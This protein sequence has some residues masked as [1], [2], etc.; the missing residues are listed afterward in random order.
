MELCAMVAAVATVL[1]EHIPRRDCCVMASGVLSDILNEGSY[2][3]RLLPVKVRALPDDG[4]PLMI[5]YGAEK[6]RNFWDG[7]LVAVVD[8]RYLVDVT[9]DQLSNSLAPVVTPIDVDALMSGADVTVKIPGYGAIVYTRHSSDGWKRL[10][11]ARPKNRRP[12]VE[13]AVAR[14]RTGG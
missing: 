10:G 7:H 12:L 13:I 1:R 2:R 14:M 8:R 6:A 4:E 3:C 9:V 5:G 11:D